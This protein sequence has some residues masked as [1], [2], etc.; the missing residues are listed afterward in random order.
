MYLHGHAGSIIWSMIFFFFFFC[1]MNASEKAAHAP[2]PSL[3]PRVHAV[4]VRKLSH[5][6]PLLPPDLLP[7]NPG[8]ISSHLLI[9]NSLPVYFFA[10]APCSV[11]LW[12]FI[13]KCH[14][15]RFDLAFYQN[16]H[17]VAVLK[18]WGFVVRV[19]HQVGFFPLVTHKAFC[20]LKFTLMK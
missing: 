8:E 7:I 1:R 2:P 3:V 5:N 19:E 10:T 9:I 17:A 11:R 14:L 15:N 20:E 13:Q 18:I 12:H 6:N 16:S 4:L